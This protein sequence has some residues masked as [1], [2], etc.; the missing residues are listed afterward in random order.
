MKKRFSLIAENMISAK[1]FT[2]EFNTSFFALSTTYHP[3]LF[4]DIRLV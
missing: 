1:S 3:L 2:H 4:V